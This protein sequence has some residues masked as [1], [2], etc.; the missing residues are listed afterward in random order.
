MTGPEL[1]MKLDWVV[2]EAAKHAPSTDALTAPQI[3]KI[4]DEC[5]SL[6]LRELA[7][8]PCEHPKEQRWKRGDVPTMSERCGVCGRDV[9]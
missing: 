9:A 5:Y 6:L 2:F 8:A 7:V 3:H 4:M 1:Q